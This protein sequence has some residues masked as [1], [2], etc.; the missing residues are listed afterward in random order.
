M[1][2]AATAVSTPMMASTVLTP[3]PCSAA[4]HAGSAGHSW[5]QMDGGGQGAHTTV[6]AAFHVSA[7]ARARGFVVGAGV[8]A[9]GTVVVVGAGT[10]VG[11][12]RQAG[13][14]G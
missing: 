1:M 2:K 7:M 11:G 9:G 12:D 13:A 4:G 8:C 14:A 5:T 3:P 6:A 10:H